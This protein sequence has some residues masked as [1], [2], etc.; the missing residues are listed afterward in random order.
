MLAFSIRSAAIEDVDSI[1]ALIAELAEFERA[2]H[3][4]VTTPDSLREVLFAPQP[5]VWAWVA[6]VDCKVVGAALVYKRYSTWKGPVLYLED[7]VVQSE[8]RSQGIGAQLFETC[9]GFGREQGCSR[10]VWQVL[11][12]NTEAQRFYQRYGAQFEPGWYNAALEL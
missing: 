3:E 9:L 11:D 6:E 2:S 1:H 8:C 4:L 10:M 12:W 7:F 5:W